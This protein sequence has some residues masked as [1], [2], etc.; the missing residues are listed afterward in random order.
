LLISLLVIPSK[1]KIKHSKLEQFKINLD[2]S[3]K[4]KKEKV[5][6]ERK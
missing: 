6:Y 3:M 2:M 5:K 4:K 1:L